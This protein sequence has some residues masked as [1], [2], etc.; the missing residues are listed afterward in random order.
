M[1]EKASG[2]SWGFFFVDAPAPLTQCADV[3]SGSEI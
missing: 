2:F 3:D 1:H